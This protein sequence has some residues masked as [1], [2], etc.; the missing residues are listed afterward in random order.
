MKLRVLT[1]FLAALLFGGLAVVAAVENV[2]VINGYPPIT[3]DPAVASDWYDTEAMYNLYSPLVYPA[4]EGG[5]RAHLATDWEA[6]DGDLTHW[7]FTLRQGVKFHSGYEMT[8]EDI[9]FSMTRFIAMGQG[10]SGPL[11]QVTAVVVD[12]YTVDFL[13]DKPSAIFPDTLVLFFPLEK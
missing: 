5:A 3:V 13:L 9:A 8:A 12:R 1:L 10:N 11:G 4:P 7:R 2:A 6:V